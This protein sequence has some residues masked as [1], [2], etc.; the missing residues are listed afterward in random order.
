LRLAALFLTTLKCLGASGMVFSKTN[1]GTRSGQQTQVSETVPALRHPLLRAIRSLFPQSLSQSS[2]GQ[3]S[4]RTRNSNANPY[5]KLIAKGQYKKIAKLGKMTEEEFVQNLCPWMTT[6]KHYN[7]LVIFMVENKLIPSF[8]VHG[9]IELVRKTISGDGVQYKYMVRDNSWTKALVLSFHQENH[10]RFI[11]I[12]TAKEYQDITSG[13]KVDFWICFRDFYDAIDPEENMK[14]KRFLVYHGE[15][16]NSM[17]PVTYKSLCKD[18]SYKLCGGRRIDFA[19][20]LKDFLGQPFPFP[21]EIITDQLFYAY[22]DPDIISEFFTV[23]PREA[24]EKDIV[25]IHEFFRRAL[26]ERDIEPWWRE[27]ILRKFPDIDPNINPHSPPPPLSETLKKALANFPT[28]DD[29][30]EAWS[31][32]NEYRFKGRVSK[33]SKEVVLLIFSLH[34]LPNAL[35]NVVVDYIIPP[36]FSWLDVSEK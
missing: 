27:S 31:R 18:L 22:P 34:L 2:T 25:R 20:V 24:I 10:E 13:R 16:L 26:E 8:L 23:A 3:L 30:E 1:Q 6:I 7:G 12:M 33:K 19:P 9:S 28:K 15:V 17:Y 21:S 32:E 4:S 35:E 29:L 36:R 14:F 11:E 5:E